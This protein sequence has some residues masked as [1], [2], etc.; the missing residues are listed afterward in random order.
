MVTWGVNLFWHK[1][2]QGFL[3]HPVVGQA[4]HL[5]D[6]N[7]DDDDNNNDDDD[8]DDDDDEDD[9]NDDDD[10]D[11]DDDDVHLPPTVGLHLA[12]DV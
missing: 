10:D 8:D 6:E 7:D 2:D 1:A 5:H 3:L 4:V 11:N 12:C 9:N